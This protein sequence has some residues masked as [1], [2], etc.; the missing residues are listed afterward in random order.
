MSTAL[1]SDRKPSGEISVVTTREKSQKGKAQDRENHKEEK[2]QGR[3]SKEGSLIGL[4]GVPFAGYV[5]DRENDVAHI[6]KEINKKTLVH[7]SIRRSGRISRKPGID[8]FVHHALVN[9]ENVS[10]DGMRPEIYIRG[11]FAEKKYSFLMLDF[12]RIAEALP[13]FEGKSEK[14]HYFINV[15]PRIDIAFVGLTG[16]IIDEMFS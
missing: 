10:L 7:A 15:G 3:K 8:V 2:S 16:M 1:W 14:G 12:M 4:E 5:L 9:I 6:T 13:E 11:E